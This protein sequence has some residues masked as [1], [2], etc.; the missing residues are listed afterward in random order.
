MNEDPP[1]GY[2]KSTGLRLDNYQVQRMDI[3]LGSKSSFTNN[4]CGSQVELSQDNN[5]NDDDG[6]QNQ[7]YK[8]NKNKNKNVE[9]YQMNIP[10]Q[11]FDNLMGMSLQGD[12]LLQLEK[13]NKNN[14]N[15]NREENQMNMLHGEYCSPRC[16]CLHGKY[17]HNPIGTCLHVDTFRRTYMNNNNNRKKTPMIVRFMP[18][19]VYFC[20]PMDTSLHVNPFLLCNNNNEKKKQMDMLSQEYARSNPRPQA[21]PIKELDIR[22]SQIQNYEDV[23]NQDVILYNNQ[24]SPTNASDDLQHVDDDIGILKQGTTTTLMIEASIPTFSDDFLLMDNELSFMQDLLNDSESSQLETAYMNEEA[25]T[26]SPSID[27]HQ[28]DDDLSFLQETAN[29]NRASTTIP[30]SDSFPTDDDLSFLQGLLIDPNTH[31]QEATYIRG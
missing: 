6:E 2:P 18:S 15:T 10:N 21:Y 12:S 23:S 26:K 19:Q 3:P 29:A 11:E 14:N 17:F 5:Y 1:I 22:G 25:S 20:N 16:T 30:S 4:Q 24:T 7:L 31:Q 13:D 27:L 8:D 9:K 28:I